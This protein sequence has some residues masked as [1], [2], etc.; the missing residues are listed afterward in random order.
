MDRAKPRGPRRR[1]RRRRTRPS[2]RAVVDGEPGPRLDVVAAQRRRGALHRRGRRQHRRGRGEGAGGGRLRRRPRQARRPRRDHPAAGPG[3]GVSGRRTTA[4][5][6]HAAPASS[7]RWSPARAGASR[8]RASAAASSGRSR[9]ASPGA[10]ARRSRARRWAPGSP[11]PQLAVIA[12]VKRRSPSKGDIAPDLD[13][14][15][16][17]RAYEAAGADAISVLTEPDAVRRLA[18]RPARRR[19]RRATCPCCA[20]TSS[21]TAGR[22]GRRPTPAPPPSCS[23]SPSSSDERLHDLL[24]GVPRLRP[25]PPGRG[26]RP[27]R[28]APRMP[29]PAVPSSASTTATLSPWRWTLAT[30]DYLAPALGRACSPSARAASRRRRTPAAWLWPARAPCWSARRW[31]ALLATTCPPSSRSLKDLRGGRNDP[32]Q[33]L[34][35]DPRRGRPPRGR[36]RRLGRSASCSPTSPRHVVPAKARDLA[37]AAGDAL[38]VGVF[39]TQTPAWIAAAV[40]TADSAPCSCRPAPTAPRSRRSASRGAEAG[41][42]PLVIAAAG[43]RPTSDARRLRPARRQGARRATAARAAGSTG[44]AAADARHADARTSSSPEASSPPTC[45]AAIAALHPV[46]VDV[47]QRRRVGARHQGRHAAA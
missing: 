29:A 39:T 40:A 1:R 36:T 41:R 28:D 38:T 24:I 9:S 35:A 47:V 37:A 42:R 19:R 25:R 33:D 30:T 23:S 3:D 44:T 43:H 12:E 8:R 10:C 20:R 34:R 17:P 26:T 15:P 21:S 45:A 22:S 2:L 18:R 27:R 14:A 31:Y 13:A 6:P 4:P 32:R 46:A 5:Q 16:R 7:P 11:S